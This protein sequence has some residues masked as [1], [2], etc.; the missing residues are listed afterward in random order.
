MTPSKLS[1]SAAAYLEGAGYLQAYTSKTLPEPQLQALQERAEI[2]A[3]EVEAKLSS[4]G[5]ARDLNKGFRALRLAGEM[6]TTYGQFRLKKLAEMAFAV[7]SETRRR[8]DR[9]M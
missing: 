6:K 3:I 4:S 9:R 2:V 5:A 8:S 1:A 7:G